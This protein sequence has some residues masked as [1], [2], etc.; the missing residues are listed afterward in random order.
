MKKMLFGLMSLSLIFVSCSG[1]EPEVIAAPEEEVQLS[2]YAGQPVD[3]GLSVYWADQNLDGWYQWANTTSY[4]HSYNGASG[5]EIPE[6][7]L[8][9]S[10]AGSTYD[11]ARMR[12]GGKWRMPTAKECEELM[13]KCSKRW[14]NRGIE[15]TGPS[16]K[17]IFLTSLSEYDTSGGG[18][19][20]DDYREECAYWTA[21][22]ATSGD[23]EGSALALYCN[24]YALNSKPSPYHVANAGRIR[25]V[26]DKSAK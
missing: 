25:P 10:I 26:C 24:R 15:L 21:S 9:T 1:N 23:W 17:T 12:W 4:S 16:G 20:L 22:R 2:N 11:P 18:L 7:F 3:M 14:T 5:Y 6:D 13:A 8:Y 19:A